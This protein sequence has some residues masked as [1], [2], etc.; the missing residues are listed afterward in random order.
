MNG[1]ERLDDVVRNRRAGLTPE[2]WGLLRSLGRDGSLAPGARQ[3]RIVLRLGSA[4][5]ASVLLGVPRALDART[6]GA[7]RSVY[8]EVAPESSELAA[9]ARE[10]SRALADAGFSMAAR[11]GGATLVV[12]VHELRRSTDGSTS[13]AISFTV[14]DR[15]GMRPVIL[16]YS[17][18]ERPAAARVLLRSLEE[19]CALES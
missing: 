5:L 14:R 13:E 7:Q 17:P 18:G 16:H 15:R 4:I 12:E 1:D 3:W 6:F 2:G 10:L 9:F 11:P 8:V 19:R